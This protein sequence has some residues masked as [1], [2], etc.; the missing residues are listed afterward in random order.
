[1]MHIQGLVRRRLAILS[2]LGFRLMVMFGIVLMPLAILSYVQIRQYQRE[3]AARTEAAVMGQ[4]M[5]AA[6]PTVE[7]IMRGQGAVA[8]LAVALPTMLK[9]PADCRAVM[10]RFLELEENRIYT[11]AGF[12][13]LNLQVSCSPQGD[14]D[15]SFRQDL[16][17]AMKL[18]KPTMRLRT[19][20]SISNTS[21]LVFLHPVHDADNKVIGLAALSLPHQVVRYESLGERAFSAGSEPNAL[22]TFDADGEILTSSLSLDQAK[23]ML[24]VS[25]PLSDLAD[26]L[27]HSFSGSAMSGRQSVFAVVPIAEGS[28]F[29]LGNWPVTVT[30]A[31]I[32]ET[33][34]PIVVFPALMWLASLLVAQLAAEHQVLRHIRTLRDSIV[35]FADGNRRLPELDLHGAP[36]ELRRV[37]IAVERMMESVVHDE[38]ELED[39]VHQKEVLLREVHHRV[40]NNLQLIASIINMQIRKA[41][42]AESKGLLRGLQDRVMSLATIH[43]ELYQT[44]GLT[45][46]RADELLQSIVTQIMKMAGRP[47]EPLKVT[48][49]FADIR[50]TPD[51]AVPLS[52]LVTEAL[53]N[54]LKYASAP[55]GQR[56]ELRVALRRDADSRAEVEIVNSV[57][58]EALRAPPSP[59]SAAESTGLGEALLSAF[60]A[61]LGTRVEVEHGETEFALRF[62]FSPN[63]LAEAE[64]RAVV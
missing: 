53:T 48:T 45:D 42:S 59:D 28:L 13:D 22:M 17:D 7:R 36:S 58:P 49:N 31:M 5:Q 4:T 14:R 9:D 61:Q 40:K 34:I 11:F 63:A 8:G 21:V 33:S 38:A 35:A 2:R 56:P 44:S 64:E 47:G 37:G 16:R 24:P 29:L 55:S 54:A 19:H 26:G 6:V 20:G 43:R 50:L 60:A 41:R 10:Q 1:M 23:T 62:A 30:D 15:M 12:I 27:P 32:V 51:Q 46:I 39:M 3:A 18:D 57:A 52:L 25:V